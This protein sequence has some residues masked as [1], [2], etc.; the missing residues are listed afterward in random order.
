[1]LKK[2]EKQICFI[3]VFVM[4]FGGMCLEVIET[5]SSFLC[6]NDLYAESNAIEAES[7]VLEEASIFTLDMIH[8]GTSAI[9]R[10]LGNSMMRW[11]GSA[12][13]LFCIVGMFLQYLFYYQSCECKEDGQLLL[14]RSVAV[15]YIH[16]KDGEK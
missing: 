12:V 15:K 11:Q 14:C 5:D 3:I 9:C 16:Q 1:M 2:F 10:G 6:A 13:L 4:F 8:N 7:Y